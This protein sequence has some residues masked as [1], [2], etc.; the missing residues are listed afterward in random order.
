M[1]LST[2]T[3]YSDKGQRKNNEDFVFPENPKTDS[4]LFLVCDG[5]GGEKSG[6]I[7]SKLS[8]LAIYDYLQDPQKDKKSAIAKS[9]EHAHSLVQEFSKR[10]PITKG[11]ASTV[12]LLYKANNKFFAAWV[13]DSRIYQI[14]NGNI[15]FQS[16]DHSYL[17]WLRDRG[18]YDEADKS[19][20]NMK[21]VIFQAIGGKSDV[22]PDI[23]ELKDVLKGDYFVLVT[24]GILEAHSETSFTAPFIAEKNNQEILK[25]IISLCH[26]K[27]VDNFSTYI[28][29]VS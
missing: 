26:E 13:G 10:Y 20:V 23:V 21:N 5:V 22:R 16:K 17:Q 11:M 8:G 12:A 28:L 1:Q 4:N 24:D 2:P 6:E 14:R 3:Y 25:E 29:K 15:I 18:I 19:Q 7:A 9:I 27:S